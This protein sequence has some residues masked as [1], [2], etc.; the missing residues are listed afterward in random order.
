MWTKRQIILQAFDELGIASYAYDIEAE[1]L[2]NALQKLNSMMATWSRA[3]ISVGYPLVSS[4]DAGD[5][6]NET[7]VPDGAIEAICTSLAM[8][9]APSLGKTPHPQTA[10]T[11]RIGYQALL[12]QATRPPEIRQSS[13]PGGAGNK[14]LRK[15]YI[16][17]QDRIST[18]TTDLELS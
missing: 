16:T 5:I 2:Q 13:L 17:P 6:D 8:R 4:P 1:Q 18:G 14:Y 15:E 11:A 7:A 3:G 10:L 12:I 9:L